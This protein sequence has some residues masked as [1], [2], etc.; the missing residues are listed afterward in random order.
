MSGQKIIELRLTR[1]ELFMGKDVNER[2][3][4]SST[5]SVLESWVK[6]PMDPVF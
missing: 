6:T 1:N 5:N 4:I 2:A 3:R